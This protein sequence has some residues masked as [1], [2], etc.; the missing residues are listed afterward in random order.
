MYLYGFFT[1]L[2]RLWFG[3]L[4]GIATCVPGLHDVLR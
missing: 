4:L 1:R 3:Y 2:L